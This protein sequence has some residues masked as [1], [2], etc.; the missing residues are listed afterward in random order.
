MPCFPFVLAAQ[1]LGTIDGHASMTPYD[2]GFPYAHCIPKV[3]GFPLHPLSFIYAGIKIYMVGH[4]FD[5]RYAY[6]V[7]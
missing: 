6:A 7:A 4:L 1:Y 2:H 5:Y 3:V